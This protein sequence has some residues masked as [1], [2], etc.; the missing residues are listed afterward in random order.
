MKAN[1]IAISR[2]IPRYAET[3][4]M[5]IIHH[6]VYPIWYE[7]GRGDWCNLMEYPFH[8]MEEAGIA[9][10]VINVNVNYKI[11]SKYGEKLTLKTGIESYSKVKII[12]E[13][14]LYN[15]DGKLINYGTTAHCWTDLNAR[16]INIAKTHPNLYDFIERGAK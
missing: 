1:T 7:Q 11:P 15:E 12:F 9:L 10:P 2:I 6:S 5:G 4:K 14:E 3:D 8:K 13:Y 16:P